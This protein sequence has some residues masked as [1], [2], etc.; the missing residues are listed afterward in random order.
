MIHRTADTVSIAR[1]AGD[2]EV[3]MLLADRVK[4][5]LVRTMKASRPGGLADAARAAEA[6]VRAVDETARRHGRGDIAWGEV[7]RL[8]RG[9]ARR[10]QTEH[11]QVQASAAM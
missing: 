11:P 2:L 7:Y 10:P 5:D 4:P 1:T 6:F 3:R 9:L 8:R